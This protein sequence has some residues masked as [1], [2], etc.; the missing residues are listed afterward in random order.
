[1]AEFVEC[2]SDRAGVFSAHIDSSCLG[3]GGRGNYILNCLAE[4][5]NCT[6]GAIGFFVPTEMIVDG[7]AALGSRLDEVGGIGCNLEQH[8][9][10]VISDD[11]MGVGV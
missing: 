6:V 3:F 8:V 1:M 7:C 4:D 9:A 11:A 5:L 2:S 10:S